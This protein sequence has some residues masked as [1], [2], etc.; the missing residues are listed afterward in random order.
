VVVVVVVV[1][2]VV[3]IVVIVDKISV[4]EESD[5]YKWTAVYCFSDLQHLRRLGP[6]LR[7]NVRMYRPLEL[8]LSA[9]LRLH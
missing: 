9:H 1:E 7:R 3:V 8:I 6:G 5:Y 2:V 4:R